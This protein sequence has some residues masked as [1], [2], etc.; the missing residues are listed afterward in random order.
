MKRKG[1][2]AAPFS[3]GV[4]EP[5]PKKPGRRKGEGRFVNREAPPERETDIRVEV[6]TP[7]FCECGGPVK[8]ERMEEATVAD[9]PPV[10]APLVTRNAVPVCRR[11]ESCG[12][13]VRGQAPTR[14]PPP[15]R[16]LRR[17][18]IPTTHLDLSCPSVSY[19]ANS[20]CVALPPAL[21]PEWCAIPQTTASYPSPGRAR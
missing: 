4:K 2:Q 5:D 10:P 6:S 20:P 9:V 16:S 12:K 8:M 21:R 7:E 14:S 19:S 3:K 18:K 11:C 13:T 1:R 17:R 15:R